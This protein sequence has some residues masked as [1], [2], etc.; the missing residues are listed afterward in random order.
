[1]STSPLDLQGELQVRC[2]VLS[3][4]TVRLE[5]GQFSRY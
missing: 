2:L 3:D 5:N 1:M 4:R